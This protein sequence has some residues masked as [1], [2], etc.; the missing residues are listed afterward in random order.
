VTWRA[1]I[2]WPWE[3]AKIYANYRWVVTMENA[4]EAGYVTEKLV[5]GRDCQMLPAM[6]SRVN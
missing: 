5:N 1:I 3:S 4:E 2:T 6:S